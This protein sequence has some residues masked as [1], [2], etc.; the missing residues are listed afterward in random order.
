MGKGARFEASKPRSP[1]PP[2][3]G[4][5]ARVDPD[6]PR[7]T[8]PLQCP[9]V[10]RKALFEDH[11]CPEP[12]SVFWDIYSICVIE[13]FMKR[14]NCYLDYADLKPAVGGGPGRRRRAVALAPIF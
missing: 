12:G 14:S 6:T 7:A 9:T 2:G 4:V 3:P 11:K 1:H 13:W 8:P 10:C 5:G